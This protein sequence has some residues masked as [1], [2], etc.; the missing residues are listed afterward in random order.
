MSFTIPVGRGDC[1]DKGLITEARWGP[2]QTNLACVE[3][4]T[5]FLRKQLLPDCRISVGDDVYLG[6]YGQGISRQFRGVL[7]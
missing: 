7:I 1:P 3:A 2:F 5:S 6:G 4:S